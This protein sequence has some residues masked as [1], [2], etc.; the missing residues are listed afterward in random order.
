MQRAHSSSSPDSDTQRCIISTDR[1]SP[2]KTAQGQP[3]WASTMQYMQPQQAQQQPAPC[4]SKSAPSKPT[5]DCQRG[6]DNF[7]PT[8][9]PNPHNIIGLQPSRPPQSKACKG[10]A[11]PALHSTQTAADSSCGAPL[12][13]LYIREAPQQ[14]PNCCRAARAE[15]TKNYAQYEP[16][17]SSNANQ[18]SYMQ[19]MQQQ[20]QQEQQCQGPEISW[21][22]K[23]QTMQDFE[24]AARSTMIDPG[25][26]RSRPQ[27]AASKSSACCAPAYKAPKAAPSCCMTQTEINYTPCPKVNAAS[28]ATFIDHDQSMMPPP[29]ASNSCRSNQ[30]SLYCSNATQR[31]QAQ[32][33][34]ISM[35]ANTPAPACGTRLDTSNNTQSCFA[36]LYNKKPPS[37]EC[38]NQ[39]DSLTPEDRFIQRTRALF[40]DQLVQDHYCPGV[41]QAT[42]NGDDD[43]NEYAFQIAFA[44]VVPDKPEPI[45][46]MTMLEAI[47]QRIDHERNKILDN[48]AQVAPAPPPPP[49]QPQRRDQEQ[50]RRE[51][52]QQR[53]EQQRQRREQE[54]QRRAMTAKESSKEKSKRDNTSENTE[55]YFSST[56]SKSKSRKKN[57]TFYVSNN[58]QPRSTSG[59]ANYS[60]RD[61]DDYFDS[62][63]NTEVN[64]A[65]HAFLKAEQ[66]YRYEKMRNSRP[67]TADIIDHE[68]DFFGIPIKMNIYSGT[69]NPL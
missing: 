23:N 16:C 49:P 34:N 46:P 2:P 13:P 66:G 28:Q 65:V 12:N 63:P 45:D 21:F 56:P 11:A 64:E 8:Q 26:Q 41:I 55:Y 39:N 30:S 60:C 1:H 20:Q 48:C 47:K 36:S 40:F 38:D 43:F 3:C 67:F 58:E 44:G 25:Y 4:R 52:Q 24:P 35:G 59:A 42:L 17:G 69:T 50:Q 62:K 61:M 37:S 19:R 14:K 68:S 27:Q 54:Q 10:N 9:Q 57:E 7:C 33:C 5:R 31:T 15:Q 51:Q 29:A 53:R 22:G 32:C 18:S 6:I